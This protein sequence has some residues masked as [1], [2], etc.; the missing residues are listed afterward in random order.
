M[1][2][3]LRTR[4]NDVK[5]YTTKDGSI[6]RELAHPDHH[7]VRHQSLAEAIVLP[8]ESTHL[9]SHRTTEEI[10]FVL[11][12]IG[13]MR[14][15][16]QEFAVSAGDTIIIPPETSHKLHNNGTEELKVLCC[17][18]PPYDHD[19]TELITKHATFFIHG[20]YSSSKGIKARWFNE[21]FPDVIVDDYPGDLAKRLDKLQRLCSCYEEVTLIGSSFGGLMAVEYAVRYPQKCRQLILLAPA[22]NFE[23]FVLP[24]KK[25]DIKVEVFIGRSDTV[26]PPD[27]VVPAVKN[28]FNNPVI[29]L[30]EDDHGLKKSFLSIDWHKYISN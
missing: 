14:L 21:N 25:L 8:G 29:T 12:G 23:E 7:P 5:P 3:H 6:I 10:Y 15:G 2:S 27:I 17:C 1:A 9:H 24:E 19:D 30:F 11:S 26:T 20:L 28:C 13:V 16:E 18:S 22:L 4:Y